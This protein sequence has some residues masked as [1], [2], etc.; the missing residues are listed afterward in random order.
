MSFTPTPSTHPSPSASL[1]RRVLPE[2]P[3]APH[4]LVVRKDQATQARVFRVDP[5]HVPAMTG[6]WGVDGGTKVWSGTNGVMSY[7]CIASMCVFF[8]FRP[9]SN[10]FLTLIITEIVGHVLCSNLKLGRFEC[11]SWHDR[12]TLRAFD[13]LFIKIHVHNLGH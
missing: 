9:C 4:Q 3:A 5:R 12:M 1:P 8:F 10:D 13:D 6:G 2:G 7:T 11:K